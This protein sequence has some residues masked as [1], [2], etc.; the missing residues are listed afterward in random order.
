[1]DLIYVLG[2]CGDDDVSKTI[3]ETHKVCRALVQAEPIGCPG[4]SGLSYNS[5]LLVA[6]PVCQ[7]P[8]HSPA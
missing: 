6:Q 3:E 5:L 4:V 2:V 7:Y 8:A 1:M